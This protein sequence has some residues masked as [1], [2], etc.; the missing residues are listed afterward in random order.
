MLSTSVRQK[1]ERDPFALE[2]GE[3]LMGSGE[4]I[5]APEEHSID[6]NRYLNI[7]IKSSKKNS[8]TS[9]RPTHS[10]AKAKSGCC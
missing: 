3:G 9:A 2:Q 7:A 6:A 5:G 4:G 8:K 10:N 1:N